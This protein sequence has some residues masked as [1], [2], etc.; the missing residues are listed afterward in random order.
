MSGMVYVLTNPAMQGY[1]KV[2]RN[3]DAQSNGQSAFVD[4]ENIDNSQDKHRF[5]CL[6]FPNTIATPQ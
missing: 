1:V 6:M 3:L 5:K 2:G 4:V